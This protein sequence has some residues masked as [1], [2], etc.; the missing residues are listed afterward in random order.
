MITHDNFLGL[1]TG[2]A[3]DASPCLTRTQDTR[4]DTQLHDRRLITNQATSETNPHDPHDRSERE[5]ELMLG[6]TE[7]KFPAG[8]SFVRSQL[9]HHVKEH[10][11]ETERYL[12]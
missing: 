10:G 8:I 2:L 9:D 3:N 4:S 6:F 5:N 11:K 12:C 7:D 1:C